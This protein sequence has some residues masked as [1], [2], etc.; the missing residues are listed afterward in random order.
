MLKL[1]LVNVDFHFSY[2][3]FNVSPAYK[4]LTPA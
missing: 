1:A 4:I 2:Y 3:L